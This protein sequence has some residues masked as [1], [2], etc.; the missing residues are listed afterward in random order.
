MCRPI[1]RLSPSTCIATTWGEKRRKSYE[2]MS[3]AASACTAGR[4]GDRGL[5]IGDRG[6][7][8]GDWRLVIQTV[9]GRYRQLVLSTIFPTSEGCCSTPGYQILVVNGPYR[10]LVFVHLV[11]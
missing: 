3:R 2:A 8:I 4:V 9:T 7:G 5:G 11:F 1:R 6:S 10:V